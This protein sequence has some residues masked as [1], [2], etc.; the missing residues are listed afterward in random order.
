MWRWT[1]AAVLVG[2][3]L[4][5]AA[6]A[7]EM[8]STLTKPRAVA[9]VRSLVQ[10]NA[11]PCRLRVVRVTASGRAPAWRVA[12]TTSGGVSGVSLWTVV[13]KPQPLN[14]LARRIA[15]GCPASPPPAPPPPAPP[16]PPTPPGHGPG[17]S[18]T[19]VFGAELTAAQQTLVRR[20]LDAGARYY[21]S[22][23]GREVPP[24]AVWAHAD[25]GRMI[26]E[27]SAQTRP[28]SVEDARRLWEGGQV[29]HALLRKVWL[30]PT[31]FATQDDIALKI[32][33]HEA[34]HLLQYELVGER[35]LGVSGLDEIPAAGPWWVAEGA[36][37]YFA[38]LAVVEDG[39]TT[40]ARVRSGWI[41]AA[42]AS[43][44]TLRDLATLRGQRETPRPYDVYAL[45]VEQLL[46]GRDPKLVFRYY[47]AIAGGSAWPDAFSAT[48]G[49]TFEAFVA[50][51]EA[52]RRT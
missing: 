32:A 26:G 27:R 16:P 10:R 50:E 48:F 51:F 14:R 49:R 33:A 2:S 46:V 29:G 28:T 17:A 38:F 13:R 6:E 52:F 22:A 45:A 5:A 42:R 7:N 19:Y 18:A 35:P 37:E 36:A 30:G 8:S 21:R 3:S 15:A 24:F 4:A 40:L 43:T 44:A 11:A 20:G 9:A 12:A 34:F 1:I 39:A 47:E 23:L 41:Q 25:L 31:W